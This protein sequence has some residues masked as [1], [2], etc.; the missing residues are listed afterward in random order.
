M[1]N[2]KELAEGLL[3]G[4]KKGMNEALEED[5]IKAVGDDEIVI[6]ETESEVE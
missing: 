2:V 6:E 5:F 1:K 4:I 3:E